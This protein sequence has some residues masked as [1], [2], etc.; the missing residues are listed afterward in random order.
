MN[1]KIV[2]QTDHLGIYI[3]TTVADR[4]PLEPDV[5]LIPGGCVEVAPPAVPDKKA[6]LW[7]GRKWQLVDSYQGLTVYNT[8]TRAPLL[9][10]RAG[11]LPAGYTLEVPGPGQIWS[12]GHWVDDI[13]AVLDLRYSAQ[14][15]AVNKA[16]LQEITGG[17]WSAALGARHFY[18]TQIEDQLNLTGLIL[19]GLGGGYACRDEAGLSDFREHTR[20]QL[21]QVGNEFTEFK[22]QR[23]RKANDLKQALAA[24]RAASDLDAF[25][26]VSWESAPV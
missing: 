4:S 17:L 3:G 21:L 16:C 15:D 26:A 24:A 5:W 7:D 14:L 13:P 9:S 22:L 19:L 1:T 23:L 10:E 18:S 25:N 11:A 2:Y 20:D 6:A 8:T 12:H